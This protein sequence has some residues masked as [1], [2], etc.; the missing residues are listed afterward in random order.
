MHPVHPFQCTAQSSV[1]RV[2]AMFR[3]DFQT[4]F[5][6]QYEMTEQRQ[7]QQQKTKTKGNDKPSTII[8]T[9]C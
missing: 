6:E 9:A 8:I 3:R 1:H 7:Q 4:H 2:V 5:L